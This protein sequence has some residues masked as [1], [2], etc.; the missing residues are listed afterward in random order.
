M[1]AVV[2]HVPRL[3]SILRHSARHLLEAAVVPLALFYG[4]LALLGIWGALAAALAWSYGA[5]AWRVLQG[6]RLPG[7]LLLGTA[8]MT[9]RTAIAAATGSVF[10]YFLQPTL[11]TVAVAGAFLLSVPLGRPLAA[12]LADDFCPLPDDVRGHAAVR[13]FFQRISLLWALV[14]FTNAAVTLWLLVS[15]PITT[16]LWAKTAASWCL[17]GTAIAISTA[18][19][20]RSMRRH[21]LEVRWRSPQVA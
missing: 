20:A 11:G 8:A 17:T 19:F 9:A 10:V 18:Y 5:I 3:R 12:R 21:G 4:T 13:R 16:F 14:Y 1:S 2:F 15:Q 6:K 7:V